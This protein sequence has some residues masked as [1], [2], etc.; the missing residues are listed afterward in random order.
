MNGL[1]WINRDIKEKEKESNNTSEGSDE[2]VH[3]SLVWRQL[4]TSFVYNVLVDQIESNSSSNWVMNILVFRLSSP[5]PMHTISESIQTKYDLKK[6][7][8]ENPGFV[9]VLK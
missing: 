1:D 8:F 4:A 6:R 3:C 9:H 5:E 7:D 2:A